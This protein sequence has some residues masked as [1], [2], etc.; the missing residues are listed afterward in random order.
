MFKAAFIFSFFP[1]R[2][3]DVLAPCSPF[4][5]RD[6]WKEKVEDLEL[7]CTNLQEEL[8]VLQEE[9]TITNSIR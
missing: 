8:Y 4:K 5:E 3:S 1:A 2:R 7:K 6:A 9:A